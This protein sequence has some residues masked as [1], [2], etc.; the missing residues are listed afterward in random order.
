MTLAIAMLELQFETFD[1]SVAGKD[2]IM[3][4]RVSSR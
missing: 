2:A 1:R 4:A 3:N